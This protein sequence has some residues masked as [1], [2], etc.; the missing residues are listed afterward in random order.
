MDTSYCASFNFMTQDVVSEEAKIRAKQGCVKSTGGYGLFRYNYPLFMFIKYL[1][2]LRRFLPALRLVERARKPVTTGF[3]FVANQYFPGD[4]HMKSK[5]NT[6]SLAFLFTVLCAGSAFADTTEKMIIKLKTNDFEIADTDIGKL[7]VGE[8][9]T[10]VT[11]SGKTIDL[12]RTADGVEIYVDGEMLEIPEMRGDSLHE[13]DHTIMHKQIHI[14]C[15]LDGEYETEMDCADDMVFF[16][17][18]VSECSGDEEI[19]CAHHNVWITQGADAGFGQLHEAVEGH[20][21]I[22]I[23]KSH[24]GDVDVESSFEKI[25]IIE[26]NVVTDD[27]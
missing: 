17:D 21:I 20:K 8:A 26:K 7:Q 5:F 14:K 19:A 27:L 12:L 16:S 18:G 24:D 22:R 3:R 1:C 6:L 11:D 13:G 10:I 2:F 25:I 15:A 23:H 4:F 9:E